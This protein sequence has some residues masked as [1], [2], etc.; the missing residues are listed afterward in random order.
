MVL[1]EN[2][3]DRVARGALGNRNGNLLASGDF[4]ILTGKKALD[5]RYG[6][7]GDGS[8]NDRRNH[9]TDNHRHRGAFLLGTTASARVIARA[10]GRSN[11][12]RA[13]SMMCVGA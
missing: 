6:E 4:R 8:E 5:G 12:V 11:A 2:R 9:S 1:G 3:G 10:R 13:M 7:E